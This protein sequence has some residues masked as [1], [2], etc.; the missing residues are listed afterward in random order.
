M[1]KRKCPAPCVDCPG[2]RAP[3]ERGRDVKNGGWRTLVEIG[4]TFNGGKVI[5]LQLTVDFLRIPRT[6]KPISNTPST[7]PACTMLCR[8]SP[9]RGR[10]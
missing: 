4:V 8:S 7:S 5:D 10:S 6:A 1:R 9:L 2:W 3:G